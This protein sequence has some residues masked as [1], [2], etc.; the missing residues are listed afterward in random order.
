MAAAT[1]EARS[2]PD[3]SCGDVG[4]GCGNGDGDI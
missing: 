4:G 2:T 1:E 3:V